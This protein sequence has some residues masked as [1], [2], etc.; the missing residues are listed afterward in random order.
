MVTFNP[1]VVLQGLN[2]SHGTNVT[3]VCVEVEGN[4]V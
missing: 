2:Q 1:E 3:Y 4:P